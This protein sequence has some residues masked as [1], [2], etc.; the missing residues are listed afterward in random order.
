VSPA[1]PYFLVAFSLV[2]LYIYGC[3]LLVVHLNIYQKRDQW[4]SIPTITLCSPPSWSIFYRASGWMKFPLPVCLLWIWCRY[5]VIAFQ[6]AYRRASIPLIA[7]D[8]LLLISSTFLYFFLAP[9]SYS[10]LL[11][12]LFLPSP[13]CIY[14]SYH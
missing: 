1:F 6:H 9:S 3:R 2:F 4:R 10:N 8:K 7:H 14:T 13:Q 11:A 5:D 12:I